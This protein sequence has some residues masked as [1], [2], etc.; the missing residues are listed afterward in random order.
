VA[1]QERSRTL[2]IAMS[3]ALLA[4]AGAATAGLAGSLAGLLGAQFFFGV[5]SRLSQFASTLAGTHGPVAAQSEGTASAL[6][7]ATRRCG[8]AWPARVMGW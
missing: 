4:L 3:L 1:E 6:L 5:A 8:S 7:T 2:A